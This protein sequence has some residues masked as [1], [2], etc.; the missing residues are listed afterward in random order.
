MNTKTD[1]LSQHT[2]IIITVKHLLNGKKVHLVLS[3]G[4][5]RMFEPLIHI[6]GPIDERTGLP[7]WEFWE[8]EEGTE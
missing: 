7:M 8:Y 4:G 6:L 2:E 1:V 3:G 5:V